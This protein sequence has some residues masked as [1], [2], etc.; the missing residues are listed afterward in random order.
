MALYPTTLQHVR[1]ALI[2][3]LLRNHASLGSRGR[4]QLRWQDAT[5]FPK[6]K[7]IRQIFGRCEGPGIVCESCIDL[8]RYSVLKSSLKGGEPGP[9]LSIVT[10]VSAL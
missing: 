10:Y 1:K 2:P 7:L 5:Y 4:Q 3:R 8:A 9:R 6:K